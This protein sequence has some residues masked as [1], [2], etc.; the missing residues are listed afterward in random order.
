[1]RVDIRSTSMAEMERLEQTLRL[2][3]DRAVEDERLSER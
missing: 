1:M 3:L 2:A